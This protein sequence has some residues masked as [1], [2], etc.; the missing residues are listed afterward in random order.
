MS[1]NCCYDIYF[2]I[3]FKVKKVTYSFLIFC[4][5]FLLIE[6]EY[7]LNVVKVRLA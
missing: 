5:Y 1:L 4:F 2:N 3:K 7:K 6:Y